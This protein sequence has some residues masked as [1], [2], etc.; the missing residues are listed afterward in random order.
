M[1]FRFRKKERSVAHGLRRIAREQIDKAVVA[2]EDANDHGAAI[3]EVRRRCKNVRGLLRLVRE[4]FP[5][6]AEED[7]SFRETA[8]LLGGLR[9]A[10]VLR[11]TFE[12]LTKKYSQID[13]GWHREFR[14]GLE[15]KHRTASKEHDS[16]LRLGEARALLREA[17][18]RTGDWELTAD[19]W[20]A[21]APGIALS[22]ARAAE[23]F[24]RIG[25]SGSDELHHE[26]R[27][28]VRYHWSHLRLL[29]RGDAKF[30][31]PRLELAGDLADRLGKHHDLAVFERTVRG[32]PGAFGSDRDVE[33]T[34]VLARRY[35]TMVEQQCHREA[36]QLLSLEPDQLVG[37]LGDAWGEWRSQRRK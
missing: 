21:I 4:S 19:G 6:F 26:L 1:A 28:H 20:E 31:R 30:V 12:R 33:A 5:A 15:Q 11:N 16:G 2:V 29:R 23:L 13:N 3:H 8:H 25:D 37:R 32:D 22:F 9:D 17:R 14:R 34:L 27:K 7:A 36:R 35:R 18:R 24:A 10:K